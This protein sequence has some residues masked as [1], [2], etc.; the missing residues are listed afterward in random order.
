M[1]PA[2]IETIDL[3]KTYTMGDQAVA[4][5]GG[6][7]MRVE[8]GEF[9]AVM[10]PSGSGKSTFMNLL[11]CLDTPTAGQYRL[12]G[13]AVS[14]LSADERARIR[15]RR[16][17]FVFQ[18]FNLL[19]RTSALENVALPLRYGNMPRRQRL[20]RAKE[21]LEMVGLAGRMDHHPAQLSGGQ[22]QRVAIA[23]ALV[24]EPAIIL[25][26]EP[27]G[28]L[29]TRTGVE[30]M[31]I[32]QALNR[33]SVTRQA[34]TVIIVTHE[35]EIADFT[36]RCLTFRDGLLVSDIVNEKPMDAGRMLAEQA[37]T[38]VEPVSAPAK[39]VSAAAKQVSAPAEQVSASAEQVPVSTEAV[40]AG[41]KHKEVAPCPV[42]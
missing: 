23:R 1:S 12:E 10:G 19:P 30:V 39:E 25:A 8:A 33:Q 6:V 9:L 27:T 16:I 31:A 34:M 13:V 7:S 40:P 35:P 29:D 38:Q 41:A 18:S 21:M 4:A 24:C 17:G 3:K 28:A 11:G 36:N 15:N 42:S 26:D 22:Q 2:Q 20:A 14:G 5:L 32:F 37:S